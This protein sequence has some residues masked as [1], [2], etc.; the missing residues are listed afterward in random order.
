MQHGSPP[1]H[2]AP[3]PPFL[4]FALLPLPGLRD[5]P[6]RGSSQSG[7]GARSG[8]GAAAPGGGGAE[9][10]GERGRALRSYASSA[11]G[12]PGRRPRPLTCPRLRA[13]C[14]PRDWQAPAG[15]AVSTRGREAA[16]AAGRSGQA[17]GEAAF[18]SCLPPTALG[19][20][21]P[22]LSAQKF[23]AGGANSAISN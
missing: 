13:A 15:R 20:G 22:P 18:F 8:A 17:V 19:L 23:G 16:A 9:R 6:P 5:P 4:L 21:I 3:P 10:R 1:L 7:G 12:D 2:P 14:H 11:R